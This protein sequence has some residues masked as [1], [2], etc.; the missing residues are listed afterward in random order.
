MSHLSTV[1]D[2]CY[3]KVGLLCD[4]SLKDSL[5]ERNAQLITYVKD[6]VSRLRLTK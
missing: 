4:T 2:T 3:D 5:I 1:Q 6:S